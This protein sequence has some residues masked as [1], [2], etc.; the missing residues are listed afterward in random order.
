[1]F[2]ILIDTS[3]WLDIAED[4]KLTPLLSVVEDLIKEGLINLI[5]PS[6][7]IVE[8]NKNRSRVAKS[9]AKSLTT[10]FQLVKDAIRKA[11]GDAK[12]KEL[13]LSHLSDV[14]HRI[15]I[16][17][18]AAEDTLERIEKLLASATP[19][20]ASDPTKG[21]NSFVSPSW[22]YCCY[23]PCADRRSVPYVSS[24][25]HKWHMPRTCWLGDYHQFSKSRLAQSSTRFAQK[26]YRPRHMSF[27]ERYIPSYIYRNSQSWIYSPRL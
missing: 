6:I 16:L 1:M 2:N 5:V 27:T 26:R 8:F 11:D 14:D 17:G 18:G 12:R 20:E 3:V 10:H 22:R 7:V 9:S 23:C 19:I 21:S 25:N 4:Q 24:Q 13:V 15:P